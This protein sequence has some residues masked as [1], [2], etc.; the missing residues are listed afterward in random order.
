M[1]FLGKPIEMLA[2]VDN[3]QAIAAVGRGYSKKLRH[4]DRMQRVSI[5]FLHALVSGHF[6][7]SVE[8][9]PTTEQKADLLTKS[10]PAGTFMAIRDMIRIV[11]GDVAKA[12]FRGAG[13]K[14][15]YE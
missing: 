11:S 9:C 15:Q 10:L 6:R 12:S 7:V 8:H 2:E 13:E 4:I 1:E 3:T 5:G 14:L